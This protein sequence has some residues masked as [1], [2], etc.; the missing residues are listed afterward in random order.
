MHPGPNR[1]HPVYRPD[2][3]NGVHARTRGMNTPRLSRIVR[4]ERQHKWNEIP[5]NAREDYTREHYAYDL[6][7]RERERERESI[8]PP[9]LREDDSP[10]NW[11]I[12]FPRYAI[13]RK[14]NHCCL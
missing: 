3:R 13:E 14:Q 9:Q 6:T 5:F 2:K 8:G 10:A 7:I 11:F 4:Y 1:T 12:V